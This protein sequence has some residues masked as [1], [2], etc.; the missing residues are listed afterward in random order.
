MFEVFQVKNTD[1]RGLNN[2]TRERVDSAAGQQDHGAAKTCASNELLTLQGCLAHV[3]ETPTPNHN[4][5]SG[6]VRMEEP[7]HSEATGNLLFHTIRHEEQ[8]VR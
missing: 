6:H 8:H 7:H 1:A 5:A 4:A 2:S 3:D